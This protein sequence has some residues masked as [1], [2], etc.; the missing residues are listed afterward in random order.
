MEAQKDWFFFFFFSPACLSFLVM[1]MMVKEIVIF[2]DLRKRSVFT[3]YWLKDWEIPVL[4]SPSVQTT[5]C[6]NRIAC[7]NLISRTF[8]R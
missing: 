2:K 3:T 4:I 8:L 5:P 1:V 6:C 7:Y